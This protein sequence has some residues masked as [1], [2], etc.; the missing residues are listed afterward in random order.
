MTEVR[1]LGGAGG[2][3]NSLTVPVKFVDELGWKSGDY[4]VITLDAPRK[5]LVLKKMPNF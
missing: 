1:K 3:A 4:I 2:A 5:Q